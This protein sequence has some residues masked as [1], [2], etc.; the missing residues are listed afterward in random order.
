[1]FFGRER[2]LNELNE[3]LSNGRFEAILIYGRRR[4]GKTELIKQAAKN[5]D[6]LYIYYECKRSLL[7]DNIEG[8]NATIQQAFGSN[9]SF[10]SIKD[11]LKFV[12]EQ[13]KEKRIL[14]VID[15]LPF[16]LNESPTLISDIRD[17][18]DEYKMTTPMKLILS[19]SYVDTMRNLNDGKSET[20]GRFTGI[21]E[22]KSFDY[23]DSAKFYPNYSNKD[24]LL[25]YSVFGGV[26]FFN[27]LIDSHIS[28]VENIKKLII[29][30]NSILQLEVEHTIVAETSKVP[31]VNSVI[32][33]IGRGVKKYSDISQHLSSK[34]DAAV[35]PDYLIKK[36]VDLELIEKVVPINDRNNKKKISYVFNDNL[37]EFYYRYIFRNKSMNTVLST[38][39]F[40]SEIVEDDLNRQFLP[41]KFEKVSREFLIRASQKHILQPVIYEIGTYSFD[42]A[43]NKINRQFDVV[44]K[45]KVGYIAY[46]C[47]YTKEKIGSAVINEETFQIKNSGLDVYKLGFISKNGFDGDVSREDYNLF[48]LSDF[49]KV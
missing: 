36:L 5:F 45:D 17:L 49:Y 47:K 14:L 24:K 6:G 34:K 27:S 12:F 40:Y 48:E 25:M 28:A 22:L 42:D 39:D 4:I 18:I 23:Y 26:A 9:F 13:A 41:E 10:N 43:K 11:A 44:T 19:G 29:A 20:Y 21:I 37:M 7:G 35:S 3:K 31:L 1:M 8:L 46:E 30:P 33:L 38:D 2:E 16:M 15:E 32:E